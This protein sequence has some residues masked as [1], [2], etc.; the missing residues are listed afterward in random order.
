MRVSEIR[1]KRIRVNQGLGVFYNSKNRHL[2][3]LNLSPQ[4]LISSKQYYMLRI[5]LVVSSAV[6]IHKKKP[7]EKLKIDLEQK[8]TILHMVIA[9]YF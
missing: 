1:V 6:V 5:V 4:G 3:F 8:I 2:K 7:I 9:Y